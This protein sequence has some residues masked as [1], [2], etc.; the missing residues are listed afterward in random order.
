[1]WSFG[2][3][4]PILVFCTY[5]EKSCNPGYKC[6]VTTPKIGARCQTWRRRGSTR[7]WPTRSTTTS[8]G[9]SSGPCA[10]PRPGGDFTSLH[11]RY[12][13]PELPGIYFPYL[14]YLISDFFL[15]NFDGKFM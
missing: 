15:R 12:L 11:R 1:L 13:W 8:I 3:F 2:E 9:P 10:A 4:L 6:R 7:A 5:K 14:S